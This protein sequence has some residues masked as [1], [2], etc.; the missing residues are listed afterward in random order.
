M[1]EST[2]SN[3]D[4]TP[5][6][7]SN[8]RE[9][10]SNIRKIIPGNPKSAR[11]R[12]STAELWQIIDVLGGNTPSS[13]RRYSHETMSEPELR[14]WIADELKFDYAPKGHVRDFNKSELIEIQEQLQKSQQ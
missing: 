10:R 7:A 3:Q 6:E 4:D 13:H 11:T 12:L 2:Q 8:N 14:K 9:R 5:P 1:P